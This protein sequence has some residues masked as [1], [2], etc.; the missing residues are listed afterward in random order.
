VRKSSP[1]PFTR[2]LPALAKVL[3][4]GLE[5]LLGESTAATTKR[6]SAPELQQHMDRIRQLSKPQQRV[7]MQVLESV[8]A[9]QG[10]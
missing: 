5:E 1:T 3:G 8:L 9:Q 4:V 2:A 7:V 6:G 10:R